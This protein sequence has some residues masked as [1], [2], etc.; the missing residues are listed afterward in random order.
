MICLSIGIV[1][2]LFTAPAIPAWYAGLVK[3]PFSPPNWIF[4]PAWTLLYILM[5]ISFYLIWKKGTKDKKVRYA[6][7]IFG[8]QLVLNAVWSPIFFGAKN[9]FLALIVIILMWF[10]I[11]KTIVAF[12]KINKL[13]SRL[14][15]PYILWVSF[16]SLLNFSVWI[17]NR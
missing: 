7:K 5:G 3:P 4:A 1:G 17:L 6:I 16:A 8:V 11:G 14:L 15:Y 12:G 10:F 9:M 13:A 2:S